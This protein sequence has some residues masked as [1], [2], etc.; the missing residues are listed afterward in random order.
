MVSHRCNAR[1]GL[2]GNPSDGYFGK[3]LA[4]TLRDLYAEVC[5]EPS[6]TLQILPHPVHDGLQ[7][8]SLACLVT[9][10]HQ[11]GF[12]GGVRLLQAICCR[13]LTHCNEAGI[14]LPEK[15]PFS[16]KYDTNIPRASGLAGSS[17]IV[18][19]AFNCLLDYFEVRERISIQDR[20]G[21]ILA[22]EEDLNI[23]AGLQDRVAQVYGGLVYMDFGEQHMKQ[24]GRGRYTPLDAA[25]L[26]QLLVVVANS[27]SDSG[28]VHSDVRERWKRGDPA[29]HQGMAAIAALAEEGRREL[30]RRDLEALGRSMDANFELRR[31]IFGDKVIGKANL[32]MV[33]VARHH[34]G[35][36]KLCGSGGA[37]VV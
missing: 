26:P 5:L 33:E 6:D 35:S 22:A 28:K 27:P 7:A 12:G 23:V 29:V 16:L 37:V 18:C 11:Y 3:T 25:L 19:A 4:F 31:Q 15:G 24:S 30:E 34:G 36:A 32:K 20:P 21:I 13:F 9:S 8:P 14:K 10:L 1:V 17:A 2:L